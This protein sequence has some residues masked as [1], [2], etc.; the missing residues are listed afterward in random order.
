MADYVSSSSAS[1][2]AE[3]TVAVDAAMPAGGAALDFA[4]DVLRG[5]GWSVGG[6]ASA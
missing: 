2:K 3:A 1:N 4:L 5:A 6:S